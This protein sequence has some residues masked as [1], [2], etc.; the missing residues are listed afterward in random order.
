MILAS[1]IR[2]RI[3]LRKQKR[4]ARQLERNAPPNSAQA[5]ENGEWANYSRYLDLSDQWRSLIITQYLERQA[6]SL[7]VLLP[8][9]SN[10]DFYT[11]VAWDD[12]PDEPYYF[13][14]AGMRIVRDA[15][16]EEQKHHREFWGFWI[17]S[18]TGLGGVIIGVLS[19]WP[20]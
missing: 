4:E 6:D 13:T 18:F 12:H 20:K 16:R 8:S 17:T 1:Y 2:Y 7:G 10:T 3:E 11:R 15:V 9:R 14:D 5:F 19:L